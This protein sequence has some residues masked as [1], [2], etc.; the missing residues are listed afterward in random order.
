MNKPEKSGYYWFRGEIVYPPFSGSRTRV[1][2]S[3]IISAIKINFS[4]GWRLIDVDK[5]QV[6]TDLDGFEGEWQEI[7]EE[8]VF[9]K[10]E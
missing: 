5:S 7:T 2:F 1:P 6:Y 9:G 4:T 8:S 10:K 3:G